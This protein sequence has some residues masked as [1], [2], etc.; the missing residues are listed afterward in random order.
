MDFIKGGSPWMNTKKGR[1]ERKKERKKE[2]VDE[3]KAET[4]LYIASKGKKR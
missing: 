1:E 3:E 4:S 2:V